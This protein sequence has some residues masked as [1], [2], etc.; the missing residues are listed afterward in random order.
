M[1]YLVTSHVRRGLLR[2]L[3]LEH[4]EGSVSELAR[5]AGVSFAAAHRELD[6]MRTAGLATSTRAGARVSYAANLD[7]PGADVLVALLSSPER[8]SATADDQVVRGWLR[9]AGAPLVVP[10]AEKTPPLSEVI[11]AGLRLAHRD[12]TVARVLPVLLWH[13]R[14]ADLESVVAEATRCNERQALG[15]FLQLAGELGRDRRLVS[16]ARRLHDKRRTR[17]RPFFTG[18]HGP[19]ALAA[20]RRNTPAVAKRWGFLMNMGRDSFA[21]AFERHARR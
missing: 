10:P 3:W 9:A 1:S 8:D 19:R 16:A 18:P 15:L 12:A 5:E 21:A 20:A 17:R 11:G 13:H 6:A 14:D 2:Q 4:A 7:H